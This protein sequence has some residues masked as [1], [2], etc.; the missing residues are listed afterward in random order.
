MG[1]TGRTVAELCGVGIGAGFA[2][3]RELAAFFARFGAWSWLGVAA[4]AA[5]MGCACY[6]LLGCTGGTGMPSSWQ[7]R[8]QAGLWQGMFAMLM[9]AT[10]GAMLSAGG[11]L[12]ALAPVP[13]SWAWGLGATLLLGW[14]L[15]RQNSPALARVSR[16]LV[17]AVVAMMLSGL[18]LPAEPSIPLPAEQGWHS[19]P[20]GL[21]YGGFNAALAAPMITAAGQHLS[22]RQRRRTAL[23]FTSITA[24]LLCCGNGVLLRHPE[25]MGEELP[26]V[27]LAAPLGRAGYALG[28]CALYLAAV[29]TLAACIGGL[30]ALLGRWLP[31]GV[32]ALGVLALNGMGAIVAVVYPVLGG[33][34]AGLL[35]WALWAGRKR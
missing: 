34:C 5:V 15:A 19:L 7:G 29:T 20:M 21:C 22:L 1:V 16:V 18:V 35:A 31:A 25:V 24:A 10:G 28:V 2:S 17:A 32:A 8:W 26:F 23:L 30:Q 11:G 4:A 13:G 6:G 27:R 3:G 12:A 9:V 33:L 14:R